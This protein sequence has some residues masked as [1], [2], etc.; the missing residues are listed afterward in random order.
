MSL[1]VTPSETEPGRWRG[2]NTVEYRVAVLSLQPR[3]PVPA[4]CIPLD[5][6][7][8]KHPTYEGTRRRRADCF[9]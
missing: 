5:I 3:V 8:H 9:T 2:N 4:A 6:D 1:V 7:H